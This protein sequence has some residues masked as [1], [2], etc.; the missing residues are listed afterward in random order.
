MQS[1]PNPFTSEAVIRFDVPVP[2]R[3]E[4][5]VYDV[6]GRLVRSLEPGRTLAPGRHHL[7]WNGVTQSG[8]Q[9]AP[10]V[11][12]YVM[13]AKGFKSIRRLVRLR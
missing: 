5:R 3:V 13:E 12:F 1:M 2:A 9:A 8:A 6:R 10:G 11:Y 4:L 7:V